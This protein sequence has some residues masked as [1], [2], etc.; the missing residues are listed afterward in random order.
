MEKKEV[1]IKY[2]Y[3][4]KLSG[5]N[6]HV[7]SVKKILT[8][9][10]FEVVREGIDEIRLAVPLHKTDISLPA[11]LVE[12]IVRI[13]GLDNIEIPSSITISPSLDPLSKKEGMKNKLASFLTGRGMIEIFTNSITSSKYYSEAEQATGVR[14]MNSLSAELDF[15]RPSMLETGLEAISYNL[16]RKNTRLFL[17]EFGKTYHSY[18]ANQYQE[19]E[20]LTLYL[21]GETGAPHWREKPTQADYYTAKGMVAGLAQTVGLGALEFVVHENGITQLL[22]ARK[23]VGQLVQVSADKLAQFNIRQPVFMIDLGWQPL[24]EAAEQMAVRYKEVNKFPVM[25]RDL[26]VV[27]DAGLA[28]SQLEQSLQQLKLP[29]LTQ[30]RLFDVFE[31]EK[32]GTNK[33]SLALSFFFSD[34]TKTLTDKEVDAMMAKIITLLEKEVQAEIRK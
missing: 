32:L 12:E 20:H 30:T 6:Y 13:D 5:K 14:M 25:Q 28:F 3:L 15:M 11:D 23:E 10:G 27:V 29:L 34:E 1:S 21:T 9:L 26:S 24:M 18:K 7:E 31:S 19:T 2:H 8:A 33:K 17:F 4:K 16:N 22:F